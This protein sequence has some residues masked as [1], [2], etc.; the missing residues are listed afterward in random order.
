MKNNFYNFK[1]LF[2]LFVLGLAAC[3]NQP[4]TSAPGSTPEVAPSNDVIAEGRLKPVRAVSLS[5]QQFGIVEEVSVKIGDPVGEGDLLARLAN[6]DQ[7]EAQLAA[8]RLALVEAQQEMDTLTRT[9]ASNLASTWT[10]YMDAQAVRADA[11]REWEDLNVEDIDERIDDARAELQDRA[12]DLEEAQDEFERYSDLDE[13]N[14]SRQSAED[15]LETTQEDYNEALRSLEEVTRERDTVRAALDAALAAEA[16]L[17]HQYELSS[18][19]ANADQLALA[20]ARLENAQAQVSA[21]EDLL[22]HYLLTA[23]FDGVIVDVSVEVGEQLAAGSRAVG[24]ADSSSWVVETT[25][26]TEL[27]VVDLAVG[28][29]V[30]F[31]ADALPDVTMSGTVSEISQS[32]LVQGGDVIYTVRIQAEQVDPRVLWGMTVEVVFES[33]GRN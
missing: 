13:D 14:A 4:T 26:V 18:E 5:F 22:T 8:A 19:G 6:A 32:S 21:A 16:E 15:E 20:R 2:M 10:A 27:E 3:A 1:L 24:V 12:A 23:P 9:G 31:T 7:A 30:T 17:R 28:Q 29:P 33:L 11:E 25:D